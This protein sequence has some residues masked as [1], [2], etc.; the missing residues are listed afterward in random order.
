[1]LNREGGH[2]L[3]GVTDKGDIRGQDI[4][5]RTLEDI[6]RELRKIDPPVFPD[7]QTIELDSGLRVIVLTVRGG[8]GP[9]TYDGRPY[10]RQGATTS[11]MPRPQYEHQ[12]LEQMHAHQRWE[13]Q[14]AY[15]ITIK[16]L[17]H[18]EI[19]R[20]I[21]ESIRRRRMEEP[22][23]RDIRELLLGL[24]L[25]H[26]GKLLN[27][28][29]VLFGVE[30]HLF[31]NYPQ[32]RLRMARF[33]GR[34]KSEFID[35]RQEVGHTFD[36]LIRAQRFL[37][38]HLPVAGRIVPDLFER[39]DEPL[40][41]PAALR[42]ALANA[43]CHRD[44]SIHG[45][46]V[47]IAIYDDRLEIASAGALHFG[48][49]PEDLMRPHKSRPWNPLIARVFYRRGIIEEWGRGTLKMIEWTEQ[50]GLPSPE[51]EASANDVLVRF[52]PTAY[53][54]PLRVSHNLTSLQRKLL[55]VLART[56]P[57]ALREILVELSL[58][59]S[60]R[61]IQDNLQALRALELVELKGSGWAAKWQLK[62]PDS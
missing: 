20:T 36:L 32:C 40:Y 59:N 43:F 34:D 54:A 50:A 42:E 5:A 52:R 13:N 49:T 31:P 9:Y 57:I 33:R 25:I 51:F 18:A 1:M 3:F 55:Q 11:V 2:V 8:S 56:G 26:E 44:Y 60:K 24:N 39:I 22:E 58:S 37:R 35:N 62:S 19:V 48:L 4:S 14:P 23:T 12:L 47:D 27:A 46:A 7:I 29:V 30:S 61:T 17:D 41:P 45:G 53:V 28:A 38:D 16:D 10:L 21:D 6:A 15:G